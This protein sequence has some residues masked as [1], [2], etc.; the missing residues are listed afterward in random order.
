MKFSTPRDR[1][2]AEAQQERHF[3][4]WDTFWGRPGYGAPRDNTH[5]ENLMKNL[6]FGH[7]N[8]VT[9]LGKPSQ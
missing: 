3:Q 8:K 4:C 2:V 6:Y 1:E 5:R 9:H 7:N